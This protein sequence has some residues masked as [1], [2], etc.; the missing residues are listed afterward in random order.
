[1]SSETDRQIISIGVVGTGGIASG[2]FGSVEAVGGHGNAG[3][4]SWGLSG[5]V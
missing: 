2:D 5:R 1:M 3:V 4:L